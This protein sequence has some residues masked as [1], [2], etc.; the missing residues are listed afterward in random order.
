MTNEQKSFI[1]RVGAMAAGDMKESR[2]LASLKIAQ[3]IL[4]SGWGRST[5]TVHANNL[6]GIKASASWRGRTFSAQTLEFYDGITPTT[7]TALFRAYGSW[8]ESIAD[9]SALL[10][11]L[12]RYRAVV[13]ETDYNKAAR[14]VHAA[15]YATD[16]RYADKL[17]RLIEMYRLCL[18]DDINKGYSKETTDKENINA[19][20]IISTKEKTGASEAGGFREAETIEA[21]KTYMKIRRRGVLHT[22]KSLLSEDF[23]FVFF[24]DMAE[25][26]D[27][28]FIYNDI[29]KE[30]E[31][32][33]DEPA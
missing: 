6:Y 2:I 18:Y 11:G 9:H 33:E 23:N 32:I 17:I 8:Q 19:G 31:I 7:I 10:T 13:G 28:K 5:L 22:A 30:I 3:A 4:E 15:G 26:F 20:K 12:T 24:R 27:I 25:I 16:P 21:K 14:A 1:E 29:T